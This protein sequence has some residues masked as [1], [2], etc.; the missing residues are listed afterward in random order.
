[1]L[2]D[3]VLP[4]PSRTS[5]YHSSSTAEKRALPFAGAS[6]QR[7]RFTTP[8]NRRGT[9]WIIIMSMEMMISTVSAAMAAGVPALPDAAIATIAMAMDTTLMHK[10]KILSALL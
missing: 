6:A 1:M 7:A 2:V 4:A 8:P 5:P 9:A 10:R 3:G